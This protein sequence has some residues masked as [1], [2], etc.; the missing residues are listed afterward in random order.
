MKE[1]YRIMFLISYI[2]DWQK[3]EWEVNSIYGIKIYYRWNDEEDEPTAISNII[4]NG[5]EFK[6]EKM[7]GSI[8]INQVV[9]EELIN[10]I[11]RK[12]WANRSNDRKIYDRKRFVWEVRCFE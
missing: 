9:K 8:T 11:R 4:I 1:E 7:K 12:T 5:E 10:L 2:I 3:V 6:Q